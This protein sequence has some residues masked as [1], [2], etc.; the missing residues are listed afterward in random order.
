MNC[1]VFATTHSKEMLESFA[2]VA[3]KLEEQDVSYTLLLKNKEQKLKTISY[4]Y[5]MLEYS[6]LQEHEVR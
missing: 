4:D 6:M 5:E 1:Q 2:R 3:K